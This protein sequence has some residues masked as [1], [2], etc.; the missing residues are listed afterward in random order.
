MVASCP[1]CSAEV[2]VDAR[3]CSSCGE[4]L[5]LS[6]QSPFSQLRNET[7]DDELRP[8]TVLFADVVG[9]TSL[10]ERLA[11]DEVKALVGEC[12]NRMSRAVEEYGGTVQAYMGDGICA[13]FGVPAAHEDDP[14]RAGRAAMRILD[15]VGEY[16]RDIENAWGISD[17]NVRVGVNSGQ[18]A[19]GLVGAGDPQEVALGDTTNVAARLQSATAP[20]TI[21]I[22]E[23]TVERLSA[24]FVLEPLGDL[25]LKGREAPVR[26]W[27]LVS[28]RGS[29]E[30]ELGPLVGRE[31][32]LEL[33]EEAVD[34]LKAG[35]GRILLLVGEA[36]IGKTRLLRELNV[37]VGDA[38]AWI[39]GHCF[40][41]AGDLL[42]GPFVEMLR[43]WAGVEEGEAEIA[44]RTRLRARLGALLGPQVDS[45]LPDLGR[46]LALR[47]EPHGEEGL[48]ASPE[49][50]SEQVRQAYCRWVE[51]LAAERPLTLAL[52]DL[53]WA[54][55]STRQLAEDLLDLTDRAPI[56]LAVTLAP[57]LESEAWRFRLH[58]LGE[59]A[60]RAAE[61]ELEPLAETAV[62]QLLSILHPAE[63]PEEARREI[64]ARAEGNPLY[65]RVFARAFEEGADLA[66]R[67]SWTLAAG[68]SPPLP[69]A[70]ESVVTAR[71]DR[72]PKDARRLAQVAAVIGR[73]FP[74]RVLERVSSSDD[75][76]APIPALLRADI[77]TE[78]RRYPELEYTFT[79]GLLQQAAL[80]TLTPARQREL[81]GR[82]AAEFEDLFAPSLDN[83]LEQLA[84]YYARSEQL[85][86]ALIY[87]ERAG[88]R[89][90]A[91][92][93]REH[94]ASLWERARKV[95]T[96]LGD[97]DAASRIIKRL[98]E[99]QAPAPPGP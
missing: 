44:V 20:G 7:R 66:P 2:A 79:H 15:V 59:F 74:A 55:P 24:W 39:E 27:R 4:A 64:I 67:R 37:R 57:E 71:I 49:V 87:L 60:H 51:A 63:L 70:L 98:E 36:G 80:S 14:E 31:R 50:L 5:L 6:R 19:V 85:H 58:V 93:S 30:A 1:S 9:S 56:L 61:V 65:L 77:I 92:G 12:V 90:L 35:R 17:F 97:D 47:L 48:G 73:S 38:A 76:A 32:E 95:A 3:F 16:A 40:S 88:E 54:D 25:Q 69:A 11:P 10:G 42:Y 78:L 83:Y 75:D 52:E 53:H 41:Y 22:G 99:V 45:V 84:F 26:A 13:L 81:Y 34:E 94:A 28:A 82:V 62:E 21:A 72:L 29:R 86:K 46:L 96:S 68:R 8:V 23:A 33:I 91:L 43:T 89:A 18:A